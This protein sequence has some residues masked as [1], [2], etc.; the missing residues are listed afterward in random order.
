MGS[1]WGK[2]WEALPLNMSERD[3]AACLHNSPYGNTT[4]QNGFQYHVQIMNTTFTLSQRD[5]AKWL[6]HSPFQCG[7]EHASFT[8]LIGPTARRWRTKLHITCSTLSTLGFHF[9]SPT[10]YALWETALKCY[11]LQTNCWLN[12]ILLVEWAIF[13]FPSTPKIDFSCSKT[14][15]QK[16]SKSKF[17][18]QNCNSLIPTLESHIHNQIQVSL[19][20]CCCRD[21]SWKTLKGLSSIYIV[22][23]MH[24]HCFQAKKK[25]TGPCPKMLTI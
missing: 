18:E 1:H 3:S 2:V 24:T 15:S 9:T 5:D 12:L 21:V 25:L 17:L 6:W 11:K 4:G 14:C 19:Q 7:A 16:G 20:C 23:K 10:G 8:V 13:R 22:P